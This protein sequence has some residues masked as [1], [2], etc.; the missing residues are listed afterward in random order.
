MET[1]KDK[2]LETKIDET[3]EMY[4]DFNDMTVEQKL[5]LQGF[6]LAMCLLRENKNK[7]KD[8]EKSA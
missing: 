8:Q 4:I 5:K 1:T 6:Y 7:N 2:E 3:K